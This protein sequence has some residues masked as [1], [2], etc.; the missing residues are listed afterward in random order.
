MFRSHFAALARRSVRPRFRT[1][2]VLRDLED[3]TTPATFNISSGDEAG[4]RAALQ[5][6]ATNGD[7]I[8]TINLAA[9]N[10]NLVNTAAGEL[11]ATN[12]TATPDML[13]TI[14]GAGAATT[15]IQPSSA[16]TWT[17]R[18]FEIDGANITVIIQDLTIQGGDVES[19]SGNNPPTARG[20]GLFINGSDVTLDHATVTG[21][22]VVGA[23]GI[24]GGDGAAGA[25]GAGA[26]G[27]GDAEG[28]GIYLASGSLT[29]INA[30]VGGNQA[31][32]GDG[33]KGGKG[34]DGSAGSAGSNG[35]GGL[36]GADGGPS[37]AGQPGSHGEDGIAGF[38]GTRGAR[39]GD[40][41]D[42]GAGSGG[43]IFVAAGT[44]SISDSDLSG[45]IAQ[46]GLGGDG[47]DGGG[48][49]DGGSGGH[50]GHGGDGGNGGNGVNKGS[51][52]GNGGPGGPGALG[53]EGADGAEGA[54]G[55][56]GGGGGGGGA[57]HGGAVY[58]EGGDATIDTITVS[59]DKA[60]GGNG[61]KGGGGGDGGQAGDGGNG[62]GGGQGG[63][64]GNGGNGSAQGGNGGLGGQNAKGALS[65][66]GGDGGG[67]GSGGDGGDGGDAAGGGFYVAGGS[68]SLINATMDADLAQ[69]GAGAAA[70]KGG[71]GKNGGRGGD[72]GEG[73]GRTFDYGGPGTGGNGTGSNG[74]GGNGLNGGNGLPGANGGDGGGGGDGGDGGRGGGGG[75]ASGGAIYIA[76]GTLD[77]S[78]GSI[79]GQATGGDGGAGGT[80]GAPG[81]GGNAGAG[82]AGGNAAWGG[83]C[84]GGAKKA[85]A[86]GNSGNGARGGDGGDGGDGGQGGAGGPGGGGGFAR[87][88]AIFIEANGHSSQAVNSPTTI[89]GKVVG[90]KPGAG[91][92]GSTG[93]D[94]G[95]KGAAGARGQTASPGGGVPSGS[96]GHNG[97]P[98]DEGGDGST[99]PTGRSGAKGLPGGEIGDSSS[100]GIAATGL[101]LV[102]APPTSIHADTSFTIV[103]RAVN[104]AGTIDTGFV[105]NVTIRLSNNPTNATLNGDL[106]VRAVK[107]VATF[108]SLTID[109][110]GT[111]YTIEVSHSG[112]NSITTS[113][114]NVTASQLVVTM[115]PPATPAAGTPFE[116]DIAAED[117]KGDVDT[118]FTGNVT[119]NLGSG[120]ASAVFGGTLTMP[121]V[122][123]VAK[124]TNLT[125]NLAGNGYRV[126]ASALDLDDTSTITFT[127]VPGAPASLLVSTQPPGGLVA[128]AGFG[129][130]V[131]A[132]DSQ[133]NVVP[134][135]VGNITL[136]LSTNPSGA[137]FAGAHTLPAI[138]GKATFTGQTID[139]IGTGYVIQATGAGVSAGST[140]PFSVGGDRLVVTTPPPATVGVN[141]TF[142]FAVSAEDSFGTVDPNFTSGVTIGIASGPSGASLGGTRTQSAVGGVATF[143]GLTLNKVGNGYNLFAATSGDLQAA[144]AG[145]I[146]VLAPSI[147]SGFNGSGRP[148][149]GP[150]SVSSHKLTAS[151][152]TKSATAGDMLTVT[153]KVLG[154]SGQPDPSYTGTVH[155]SSTDKQ[156]VPFDYQFTL[157]DAGQK[158]FSLI[159]KTAGRQT[160]TFAETGGGSAKVTTRP[161]AI[162]PSVLSKLQV[163]GFPGATL[164]RASHHVTV[165]AIDTYGNKIAGYLGTVAFNSTDGRASL[166][167][168][169]TFKKGD[170][171]SHTFLATL[172]SV[173]TQTISASDVASPALRGS[174]N[175]LVVTTLTPSAVPQLSTA[176]ANQPVSFLLSANEP[177]MAANTQ[178]TFQIDW[179]GNG[180]TDQTVTGPSG[181][182]VFHQFTDNKSYPVSVTAIDPF[183]NV[184]PNP[185][186][187]SI[188]IQTLAIESDP[189]NPAKTALAIGGTKGKDTITITS[190]DGAGQQV[191]VTLNGKTLPGGPFMPT[192]HI[193][194]YGGGGVDTISE[195]AGAVPI[196]VPAILDGGA[197]NDTISAVGSSAANVLIGGDGKDLLTAGT[198]RT[199]LI[200]GDGADAL[201]AGSDDAILIGGGTAFDSNTIALL[202]V[203]AEW[204]RTDIGYQTRVHDLFTPGSGGANG[205]VLLN[206]TTV[207]PDLKSDLLFGGTAN[208]WFWDTIGKKPDAMSGLTASEVVTLK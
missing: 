40:G 130:T 183:G 38:A 131:E 177:G 86:G 169:Y 171:G 1:R 122:A 186:T 75:L 55:G 82:G 197:G 41:G 49:G 8:N 64:G 199:V 150:H 68:L 16:V 114:I 180:R 66:D 178:Y 83:N 109:K 15:F 48:G 46:G 144:I 192:G 170:H 164:S 33:G 22:K 30:S 187:T 90:G 103:V 153:L 189:F 113:A 17:D 71:A 143:S 146:D 84:G 60:L 51:F 26:Q 77:L 79:K 124:F 53:G 104:S 166:P 80:G 99:G 165:T 203:L 50:G 128:S 194:V 179:D 174:E 106:T 152:S 95:Q 127:V 57:A 6:S 121:A 61:G 116:I 167:A 190:T 163:A 5:T 20:G 129:L 72:G 19:A 43:G 34:G 207:N 142:G 158:A 28:G 25:P 132:V 94:G 37:A 97:S 198:G 44:L 56:E 193:L 133:G 74:V 149:S 136:N 70:G 200:G 135:F 2:L 162:A 140:L 9:G 69:G 205:Q 139:R 78:G 108:S 45:N 65:G 161:I 10:Y 155:V 191:S 112:L 156:L 160:I 32:G 36:A 181:T 208:D 11:V 204:Q 111:G 157:G 101:A 102:T 13:L 176:V 117:A 175:G 125:P 138:G 206:L 35:A 110:V 154:A 87:G 173:G 134:S 81:D 58:I 147:L 21:N 98:G 62:G 159:L 93:G 141:K 76:G 4:L 3:R 201:H 105:G 91:G 100:S 92:P 188:Q 145:P 29:L 24:D 52:G 96:F 118:A 7:V 172:R 67:G 54:E 137:A 107:G 18:I 195:V 39:G 12:Q 42:G 151:V 31:I 120:P 182:N 196:A 184:S 27:G 202:G 59:T 168:D 148:P 185:A 123:G 47:G 119:L 115:Q 23:K 126:D 88:G 73:G 63:N 89:S 85:G 14:A